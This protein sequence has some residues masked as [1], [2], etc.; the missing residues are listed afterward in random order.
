MPHSVAVA[1]HPAHANLGGGGGMMDRVAG[2]EQQM[3]KEGY[4]FVSVNTDLRVP[5]CS[6]I[7]DSD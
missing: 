6:E 4:I 1:T 3:E 2:R 5:C 7:A